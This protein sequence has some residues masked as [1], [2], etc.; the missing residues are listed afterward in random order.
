[1]AQ[2][3]EKARVTEIQVRMDCNGCVQKIKKALHGVD[4]ISHIYVDLPQQKLIIIGWADPEKIV[5]AIRKTRKMAIICSH[6]ESTEPPAAQPLE[7]C[8]QQ[9]EG[10]SSPPS[11]SDT[12]NPPPAEAPAAEPPAAPPKDPPSEEKPSP[13]PPMQDTNA[14]QPNPQASVPRDEGEVHTIYHH[15]PAPDYDNYRHGPKDQGEVHIK[16]QHHQATDNDNH[17][18][19]YG[20][21][22]T[23]HWNRYGGNGPRFSPEPIQPI[24]VTQSY[25]TYRPSPYVTSY[26]Y[27][28]SP[29]PRPTFYSSRMDHYNDEYQENNQNGNITSMFSDENP[30]ACRI[31]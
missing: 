19:G 25:N 30:N 26:E 13:T 3:L 14:S 18:Y 2:E 21:N 4:G 31:V 24:H 23:G 1:M 29:P 11:A 12:A 6:S 15:P 20:D 9:P 10:G 17:R 16:C 22:Y 27:I 7:Q 5:R 28:Q 8:E